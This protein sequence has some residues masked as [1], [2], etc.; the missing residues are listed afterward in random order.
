MTDMVNQPSK[1]ITPEKGKETLVF[2]T[3][4]YEVWNY[5]CSPHDI[6]QRITAI[7]DVIHI[8]LITDNGSGFR[9][10]Q[11]FRNQNLWEGTEQWIG[12]F[13][14]EEDA[15]AYLDTYLNQ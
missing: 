5:E 4:T 14:T 2:K 11:L 7:A 3:D 13:D 6:R 1:I 10:Q 12:V 8:L 15:W 9:V